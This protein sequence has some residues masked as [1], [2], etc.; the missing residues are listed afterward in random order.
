ML[1]QPRVWASRASPA[2][3]SQGGLFQNVFKGYI[4]CFLGKSFGETNLEKKR[5][6]KDR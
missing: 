1:R 3:K 4:F 2:Q 5:S 6:V